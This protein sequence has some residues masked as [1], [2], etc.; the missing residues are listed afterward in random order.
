MRCGESPQVGSLLAFDPRNSAPLMIPYVDVDPIV[1]GPLTLDIEALLTALGL[2]LGV[3]LAH[4]HAR[5]VGVDT[6]RLDSFLVWVLAGALIGGHLSDVLLYRLDDV[7]TISEHQVTW[8]DPVELLRFWH[9]WRSVGGCFGAVAGALLWGQYLFRSATWFISR[10]GLLEVEGYRFVRRERPE[11]IFD[12]ADVVLSVFPVVWMFNR[13][14]SVLVHD[15]PGTRAPNE[16]LL[17]VNYPPL[18][19]P[20]LD[21][22]GVLENRMPRWDLSL[23]E[24]FLTACLLV[25]SLVLSRN[26]NRSGVFVWLIGIVY[27][28]GRIAIEFFARTNGPDAPPRFHG[29]TPTQ[30]GFAILSLLVV[31]ALTR[32][33][34]R[35]VG[36][37]TA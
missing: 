19:G 2:A 34:R 7:V 33:L 12:L 6:R 32:F 29:Y 3:V 31:L 5:R 27:P 21:G 22:F 1:L 37:E 28:L 14:G 13:V 4:G 10:D 8:E 36:A 30:W 17:S 15:R 35:R 18:G 16:A 23:L 26:V 20:V 11:R 25:L 9:G 24:L